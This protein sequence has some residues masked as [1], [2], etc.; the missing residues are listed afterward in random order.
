MN[1]FVENV[2]Y[3]AGLDNLYGSGI[4]L[5]KNNLSLKSVQHDIELKFSY[6]SNYDK[7]IHSIVHSEPGFLVGEIEDMLL[8]FKTLVESS[9][10]GSEFTCTVS[11]SVQDFVINNI[12]MVNISIVSNSDAYKTYELE[13]KV[14][15]AGAVTYD[16]FGEVKDSLKILPSLARITASDIDAMANLHEIQEEIATVSESI[17]NVTTVSDSIANVNTVGISISNVNI[18]GEDIANVNTV[19]TN[20]VELNSI[21]SNITE[22]LLADDNAAIATTKALES[23][24]SAESSLQSALDS[25][26]SAALFPNHIADTTNPHEVT[27][28]QVGLEFSE[29]TADIDKVVASA[30]KLTSPVNIS[31]FGDVSGSVS[32]DG[33]NNVNIATTIGANSVILGTD[34]TGNYVAGNTAGTG[35]V[36]TGTAGEGWSPT[37]SIDSTVATLTGAQ[38][39]TN[40]TLQD[41]TTFIVDNTDATKK[42]QF[43]VAGITTATTRTLTVPNVNGTLI[44]TG[45][46]G[47]VTSTMLLDGTIVNADINASAAIA[48]TKLA[49]ISTVGKVSNSATTATNL[50]TANSIV[51][52]DASGNFS[53]G[54]I[55]VSNISTINDIN[56]PI[57]KVYKINGEDIMNEIKIMQF[58]LMG[59]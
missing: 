15:T 57:G 34:T 27:K 44:T 37:I 13:I 55:N 10:T 31:L 49:T 25:A 56:L 17:A 43:D 42:V 24:D 1:S 22:I 7:K 23:S 28:S 45:D 53:A 12:V 16:V 33:S 20:I 18:V 54:I 2:N 26:A 40:K 4:E 48:D 39:L 47:T 41:S 52:R 30:G 58:A 21:V 3:V 36:V 51:S 14:V 38:T 8:S 11:S 6:Y 46:T 9:I 59:V 29:N 50:N 5:Y 35:I 32:F 19:A